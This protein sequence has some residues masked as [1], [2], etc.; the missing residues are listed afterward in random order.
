MIRNIFNGHTTPNGRLD[1]ADVGYHFFVD[2]RGEVWEG[3]TIQRMGTHV[4]STPSSL[5]NAG[6]L[7]ICGLGDFNRERPPRAMTEGITELAVLLARYWDRALRVRGHH[8]WTGING[9]NPV[10][11]TDC[12][13]R[14]DLA[15]R[16]AQLRIKIDFPR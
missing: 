8:D 2:R 5:N 9:Y 6:N 11:G 1:A 16:L 3:R 13:G 12:P 14:L 7:G 15:V 10:G 4:G